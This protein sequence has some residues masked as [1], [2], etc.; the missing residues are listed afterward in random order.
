M[1]EKTRFGKNF[2][3]LLAVRSVV[4][5][6][7]ALGA[8]SFGESATEGIGQLLGAGMQ[9]PVVLQSRHLHRVDQPCIKACSIR[10][11][12]CP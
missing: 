2:R 12:L 6:A 9:L 11:L 8:A 3:F 4:R 5:K 1:H 7:G 10:R